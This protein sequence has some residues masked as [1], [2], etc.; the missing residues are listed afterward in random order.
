MKSTQQRAGQ[1]R[2]R[3]S[4]AEKHEL[5][6]SLKISGVALDRLEVAAKAVGDQADAAEAQPEGEIRPASQAACARRLG[7]PE[8]SLP[9]AL[10][11]TLAHVYGRAACLWRGPLV[12]CIDT[13]E[14]GLLCPCCLTMAGRILSYREV[15][16]M[17]KRAAESARSVLARC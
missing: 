2:R 4:L 16:D 17:G 12:A 6:D 3:L 9:Q 10:A 5:R 7:K 11:D 13:H 14:H 15:L 8:G 1:G